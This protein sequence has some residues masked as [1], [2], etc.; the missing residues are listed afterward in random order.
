MRDIVT[1]KKKLIFFDTIILNEPWKISETFTIET[2]ISC[3]GNC[4]TGRLDLK[5]SDIFCDIWPIT[6]L[7]HLYLFRLSTETEYEK[8]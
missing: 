1:V 5:F 2:S 3:R 8:K 6:S 7:S 4:S